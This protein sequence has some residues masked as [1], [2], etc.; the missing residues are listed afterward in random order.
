MQPSQ[1]A[2]LLETLVAHYLAYSYLGKAFYEPPTV[3]FLTT[4]TQDHL[5]DEWPLDGDNAALCDGLGLLQAYCAAWDD[6][7]IDALKSDYAHL[8]VGPQRLAAPPWE[9]VYRSE[10][11]LLFGE[12]TLQ[13]R[14]LYRQYGMALPEGNRHPDDHF[15]LEM[16]FVAHLCHLAIEALEREQWLML[17]QLRDALRGFVQAHVMQ[18]ADQFLSD[19]GAGAA[20]R[21][22]QGLARLTAGCLALTAAT[23]QVQGET[24]AVS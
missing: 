21:Y 24:A 11:H 17:N 13:V 2:E 14:T 5:F 22:Y 18:W 12:E 7:A 23:W 4:L 8:F 6:S 16:Y 19:V 1:N 15:G 3:E 10:E 9:S 20:T